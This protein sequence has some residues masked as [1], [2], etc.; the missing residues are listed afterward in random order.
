[1]GNK[2]LVKQ[3]LREEGRGYAESEGGCAQTTS[4]N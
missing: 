2:L 1:M 3:R 4:G